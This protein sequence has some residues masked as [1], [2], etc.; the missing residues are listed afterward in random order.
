MDADAIV[1]G[2]GLAGLVA[3]MRADRGR[4]QGDP[5]RP[6]GRAV[7]GRAG[8]LVVRR[9]VLRRLARAAAHAHPRLA[10]PGAAGLA[11]LGRLRPR[12]GPLAPQVG[13]GLR[14][15]RGG[16]EARLAARP[17]RALVSRSSA[18]PSA[19]ATPPPSTATRCRASTS[20]GARGPA[21][22]RRSLRA[23]ARA[24]SRG[25]CRC[26]FAIASTRSPARPA[27]STASRGDILEPT[28]R[29][30]RT[31][32][33]AH[34]GRRFRPQGAGDHRHVG[35]HRRQPRPR[36]PE[37]AEAARHAAR[38]HDLRRARPRRRPHARHHRGRRRR[39]H[40]P[41]PHVALH[42]GH[43][44]LEPDL[45]QA[46][47]PHPARSRPPCGS[48]RAGGACRCRCSRASTRWARSR[49]SC[50]RATTTPG[51]CSARRSSSASSRCRAPSRTPTSPAAA[52]CK[53]I[54]SRR[55]GGAPPPVRAFMEKG[56]DF[57]VERNLSD[58][59]ARMNKLTG[60]QPD[61]CRRAASA[62]SPRATARSTTPSP[63]TRR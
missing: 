38:A 18:G 41:R 56:A 55:A 23:C 1:V 17:R 61:R 25:S 52:G 32:E 47:H 2:G 6:G 21:S 22:S 28:Q 42:R 11:G 40:Q 57:I 51:S 59:V 60:E 9:P 46:R 63:R 29:R 7:A 35:R 54:R 15:L 4:A 50:R 13:R 36:A 19:A 45:D 14:R 53:V 24:P 10:R 49:T 31:A 12:G 27:S 20:P 44:E 43:P 48:M 34:D 5:A 8:V 26:A 58:L 39:H 3:D 30:A 33:L 16:R 62:R 37:L